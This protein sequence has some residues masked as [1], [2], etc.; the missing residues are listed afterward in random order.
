MTTYDRT[1]WHVVVGL[2]SA[3]AR[4]LEILRELGIPNIAVVRSHAGPSSRP[5]PT[6]VREFRLL[7]EALSLGPVAVVIATPTS[8][9]ATQ[10]VAALDAGA[11]V[12]V[13]KPVATT[14]ANT[15]QVVDAATR[16]A[17]T[18]VAGYHLRAHPAYKWLADLAQSGSLGR[19]LVLQAT[20]GEYLPDWHPGEDYRQGYAARADQGGGPLLTLSHVVDYTVAVLGSVT[21]AA[22]LERNVSSLDLEV[23]DAATVTFAHE[24]GAL[25]SIEVD[26]VTRPPAH[27]VELR[28][29]QGSIQWDVLARTLTV[30]TA[31]GEG[32]GVCPPDISAFTRDDCFV[33]QM[34]S[35]LTGLESGTAP[36][37]DHELAVAR[38]V[39]SA[40]ESSALSA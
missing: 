3:G 37:L 19:P 38:A 36:D 10:S 11:S 32:S 30:E 15:Q 26:F 27:R 39:Q 17:R 21:A 33:E 31:D 23:A 28:F 18:V 34:S 22:A 1:G 7:D 40:M 35:F 25:S 13:E 29:E 9:H 2:G 8:M 14:F 16:N 20:W 4:H 5:T 24:S 12:L 6:G